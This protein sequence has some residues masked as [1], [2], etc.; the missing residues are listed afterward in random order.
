MN[1]ISM[2]NQG[3]GVIQSG[4]AVMQE[5]I[6]EN[7]SIPAQFVFNNSTFSFPFEEGWKMLYANTAPLI[8]PV[9]PVGTT[10]REH[11]QHYHGFHLSG[12]NWRIL[13]TY[14][15]LREG[16]RNDLGLEWRCEREV[17]DE[18]VI[19]QNLILDITAYLAQAQT[20]PLSG[21]PKV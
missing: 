4:V 19:K 14:L 8:I 6:S 21:K 18:L 7:Y 12:N 9:V 3:T 1:Y 10:F 15:H 2:P 17:G 20:D 13:R 16:G 11:R 5:T